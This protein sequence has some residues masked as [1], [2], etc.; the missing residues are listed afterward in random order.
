MRKSY[1]FFFFFLIIFSRTYAQSCEGYDVILVAGQSNTH[2]GYPLEPEKDIV[3]SKVYALKRYDGKD[4]RIDKATPSLDFWT[5]AAD[6]NSFVITFANLYAENMLAHSNRKV[7]IIPCGYAGTAIESWVK[8][9]T[10]YNDAISRT[11]YVLDNIPG[12]KVVAI[13]WHQGEYNAGPTNGYQQALDKLIADMR[14]DIKQADPEGLKFILGGLVPFWANASPSR[15]E[16][17]TIIKN[18]PS[19]VVNTGFADPTIPFVISKPNDY[20]DDIHFDSNGLREMGK[21]YY[22]EYIRLGLSVN[23]GGSQNRTAE[24]ANDSKTDKEGQTDVEIKYFPNPTT[25]LV[26]IQSPEE[27]VSVEVYSFFGRKVLEDNAFRGKNST[28]DLS[29]IEKGSYLIHSIT[30]TGKKNVFTVNKN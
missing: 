20:F 15:V 25:G 10:L 2:Y 9:T 14:N 24:I 19:R 1:V 8:G 30:N 22:N 6:R 23:S 5:R 27:I 16:T 4:Y 28:I 11:N 29:K 7:L 3:N 13:L 17:N 18:T 21:R 12:S 26:N